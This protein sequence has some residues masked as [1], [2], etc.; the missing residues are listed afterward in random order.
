MQSPCAADKRS[1]ITGVG[2]ADPE[3]SRRASPGHASAAVTGPEGLTSAEQSSLV[4]GPKHTVTVEIRSRIPPLYPDTCTEFLGGPR[5]ACTTWG[6]AVCKPEEPTLVCSLKLLSS[7][8]TVLLRTETLC[9]SRVQLSPVQGQTCYSDAIHRSQASRGASQSI[10]YC[11]STRQL[12]PRRLET[13]RRPGTLC[14]LRGTLRR[15]VRPVG[16]DSQL[17]GCGRHGHKAEN[18]QLT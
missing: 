12:P 2:S 3:Q 18:H 5:P 14:C 13:G 7:D 10:L 4:P 11:P 6:Y 1:A 8:S 16:A 17:A 15:A 9:R